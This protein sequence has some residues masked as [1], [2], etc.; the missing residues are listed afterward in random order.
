MRAE[1][2]RARVEVETD[3]LRGPPWVHGDRVQLQQLILNLVM[4]A[5]EAMATLDADSRK[6]LITTQADSRH[7]RVRVEDSGVGI[8]ESAVDDIFRA[9][10]TTKPEGLGMGLAISRSIVE[11][12]GGRLTAAPR[13]PCGSVFEFELP[14]S[15]DGKAGGS[16]A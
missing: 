13:S 8:A 3:L 2:R 15:P 4:N 7:I 16:G 1:L 12:H 11:L 5:V 6:L 10:Y 14:V 9:L